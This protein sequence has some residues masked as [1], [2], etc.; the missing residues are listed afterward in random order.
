M[1]FSSL[2][3][4]MLQHCLLFQKVFITAERKKRGEKKKMEKKLL[5]LLVGGVID[6]H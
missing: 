6:C 4:N 3:S 2:R 1:F 5:P